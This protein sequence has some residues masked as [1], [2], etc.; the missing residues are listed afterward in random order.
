[1]GIRTLSTI[2][3]VIAAVAVVVINRAPSPAN[4]AL[5][6]H[7]ARPSDDTAVGSSGLTLRTQANLATLLR[8]RGWLISAF[9]QPDGIALFTDLPDVSMSP[10]R[11]ID[12]S[13]LLPTLAHIRGLTWDAPSRS[14]I[15]PSGRR[16]AVDL[17]MV[18][19]G[20]A[21]ACNRPEDARAVV[22]LLT[23]LPAPGAP[24]VAERLVLRAEAPPR[25]HIV[26]FA[27]RHGMLA[28]VDTPPPYRS[29]ER[30]YAGMILR[31][32][33]PGWPDAWRVV[34]LRVTGR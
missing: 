22:D 8:S 16:P 32:E 4:A 7:L 1:M 33:G 2:T 18:Q 30:S 6:E 9:S 34:D 17:A 21:A 31:F 29:V 26:S 23:G 5:A 3:L 25:L 19:D 13:E 20:F 10:E 12:P 27:G 28:N 11:I 15:D 24:R 14:W